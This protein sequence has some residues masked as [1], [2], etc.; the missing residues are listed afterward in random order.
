MVSREG[1]GYI[2]GIEVSTNVALSGASLV[3]K[4]TFTGTVAGTDG[5]FVLVVE[6]LPVTLM[7]SYIGYQTAEIEIAK[8]VPIAGNRTFQGGVVRLP[9]S[10]RGQVG[11]PMKGV[12]LTP[13]WRAVSSKGI[14][15][16]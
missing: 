8:N 13:G 4:N 2:R 5:K 3:I 1:S 15:Q 16:T 11:P 12:R 6:S 10:G 7:V 14:G 9:S